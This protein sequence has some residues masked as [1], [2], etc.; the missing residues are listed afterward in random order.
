MT[1]LGWKLRHEDPSCR[2]ENLASHRLLVETGSYR[3]RIWRSCGLAPGGTGLF[4]PSA[5][6]PTSYDR[7]RD[8]FRQSRKTAAN[9]TAS[10][11][12]T[13]IQTDAGDDLDGPGR[14]GPTW[15]AQRAQR[16]RKEKQQ[17]HR[18]HMKA[19]LRAHTHRSVGIANTSSP[20]AS[21]E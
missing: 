19:E 15:E 2:P 9:F 5:W 14:Q 8:I 10:K 12:T 16:E 20:L 4:L 13:V 21:S 18:C 6:T 11:S 3:G 7:D 17:T 1:A